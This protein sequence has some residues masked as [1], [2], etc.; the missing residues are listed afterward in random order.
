MG[1]NKGM[2]WKTVSEIEERVKNDKSLDDKKRTELL[3]LLS[4]LKAEVSEL[5]KTHA[6]DARSISRFTEA[7]IHEA[8]REKKNPR[9]LKVSLQGLSTSVEGFENSHP[10]LVKIVNSICFTLSN[11]GL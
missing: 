10:D 8:M 1:V 3:N 7:S 11:M 9:L 2:I 5:S 6:E 4:T